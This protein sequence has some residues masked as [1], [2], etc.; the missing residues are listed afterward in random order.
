MRI[1]GCIGSDGDHETHLLSLTTEF[2]GKV[3]NA[4][5]VPVGLCLLDV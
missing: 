4:S 3:L 2:S 5:I 1:E